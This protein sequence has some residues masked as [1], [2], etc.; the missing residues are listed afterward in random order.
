[1]IR[2]FMQSFIIPDETAQKLSM[3]Q[4]VDYISHIDFVY[5]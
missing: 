2:G 1:M 5:S 4:F 3:F